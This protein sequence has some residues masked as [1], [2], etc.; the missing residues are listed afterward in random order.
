[1]TASDRVSASVEEKLLRCILQIA[2]TEICERV[3][4]RCVTVDADA[5]SVIEFLPTMIR[6]TANKSPVVFVHG[7][8]SSKFIWYRLYRHALTDW[9]DRPVYFID[10]PGCGASS[11][12]R[13]QIPAELKTQLQQA[14]PGRIPEIVS[15]LRRI[16]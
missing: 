9:A 6:N 1:M 2:D 15:E 8:A 13:I 5:I 3:R 4:H 14:E 12:R 16:E 11:P 10:L 7:F